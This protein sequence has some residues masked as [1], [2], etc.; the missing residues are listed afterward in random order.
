V[1]GFSPA[2][3]RSNGASA[4]AAAARTW[5]SSIA[6][7]LLAFENCAAYSPARLPKTTRSD[8]ELPCL[9]LHN[10]KRPTRGQS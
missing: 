10:P 7:A 9:A 5:P 3:P 1:Y 6:P 8:S 4:F 2:A